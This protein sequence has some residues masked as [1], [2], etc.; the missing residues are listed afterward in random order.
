MASSEAHGLLA[1]CDAIDAVEGVRF[2]RYQTTQ[3]PPPHS[4]ISGSAYFDTRD[5][6]L[7]PI[8]PRFLPDQRNTAPATTEEPPSLSSSISSLASSTMS[9]YSANSPSNYPSGTSNNAATAPAKAEEHPKPPPRTTSS[10]GGRTST[11]TSNGTQVYRSEECHICGRIFKG[12][13]SSTHK[14]QH[15]RRLHPDDYIPKRGGKKRTVLDP[16]FASQQQKF[17]MNLSAQLNAQKSKFL[18]VS[19]GGPQLVKPTKDVDS[20]NSAGHS[21]SSMSPNFDPSSAEARYRPY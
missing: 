18:P 3:L 21:E 9:S 6:R 20:P 15:I 19:P 5:S 10:H 7:P 12:P 1:I 13:K 17:S 8:D 11:N 2:P 16:A 14:Q 4:I